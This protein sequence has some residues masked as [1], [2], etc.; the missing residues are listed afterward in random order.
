MNEEL[1]RFWSEA[2]KGPGLHPRDEAD[3]NAPA[4]IRKHFKTECLFGSYMGPLKSAPLV[5]LYTHPGLD[6]MDLGMALNPKDQDMNASL[7]LGTLPLPGP[8]EF[9]GAWG[10]W[11]RAIAQFDIGAPAAWGSLRNKIAIFNIFAYH[12]K[13]LDNPAFSHRIPS[14]LVAYNWA[15]QSLFPEA[16]RGDRVVVCMAAATQWGLKRGAPPEGKLFMPKVTQ[17]GIIYKEKEYAEQYRAIVE[18]V[19]EAVGT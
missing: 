3:A 9:K 7:R 12:C 2:G 17:K 11:T 15:H 14:C 16:R 13:R 8:D 5:F 18:A 10:W 19:Q 4:L 1:F 6:D